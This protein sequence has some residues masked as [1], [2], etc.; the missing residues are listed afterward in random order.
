MLADF[1]ERHDLGHA[2]VGEH[3][4]GARL[5][6]L[7][8]QPVR[9]GTHVDQADED[10]IR[11]EQIGGERGVGLIDMGIVVAPQAYLR[12][13]GGESSLHLTPGPGVKALDAHHESDRRHAPPP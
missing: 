13:V 4:L 8:S 2:L 1:G 6:E 12:A 5:R 10:D 9:L 11:V 3:G 7:R